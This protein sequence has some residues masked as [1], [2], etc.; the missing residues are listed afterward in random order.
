MPNDESANA[1]H[2]SF[3]LR[4]CLVIRYW[5]FV[6]I[7]SIFPGLPARRKPQW[8]WKHGTFVA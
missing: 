1:Y 8:T 3:G 4:H 6:I 5:A 2:S 7:R